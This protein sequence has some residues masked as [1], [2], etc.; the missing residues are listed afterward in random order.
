[1]NGVVQVVEPGKEHG[2]VPPGTNLIAVMNRP[3]EL[4]SSIE[5]S[6]V[7]AMGYSPRRFSSPLS[8]C[9]LV[10]FALFEI[11]RF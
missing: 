8:H 4:T 2:E 3:Y 9:L 5:A 10:I 7:S 6:M 1:M 11:I